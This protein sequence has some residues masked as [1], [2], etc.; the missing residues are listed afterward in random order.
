MATLTLKVIGATPML[1]HSDRF[2]DPLDPLTKAHK[3][4]TSKRKKT[5]DDHEAIARSEYIGGLYYDDV[6]GVH[7][8]GANFKSCLVE[9]AKLNKLGTEFKRSLLVIDE[10]IPLQYDGPKTPETLANDPRFVLAKSVKVG[11]ARLMR[12]RPRFPAGW[13]FVA[14]IEYDESRIDPSELQTVLANAGRYIGLGDWRPATGGTYG[15]FT[16]EIA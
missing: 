1:M 15:R 14:S 3:A 7:V 10:C 16:V 9:A 2:A 12:H 8:P 11:T 6:N 13:S 5:D 4:L